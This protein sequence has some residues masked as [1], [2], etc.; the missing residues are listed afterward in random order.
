MRRFKTRIRELTRRTRGVSLDQVVRDLKSYLTG[1]GHY[2]GF[3]EVRNT[4]RRLD[5]WVRRKLR[6][7]LWKQWGRR[8][9]RELVNRG[10]ARD[11]AWS[12]S[13]AP[14]GPW[15]LSKSPALHQAL[16]SKYFDSLGLPRLTAIIST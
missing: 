11:T 6:C 12:T 15:R 13:K 9:Y 5:S 14:H 7:Y 4:L 10:V 8:G 3:A 16:S 1:W 2:F